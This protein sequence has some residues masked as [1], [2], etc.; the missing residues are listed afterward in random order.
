[1]LRFLLLSAALL[2]SVMNSFAS[3]DHRIIFFGDS[4]TDSGY[5]NNNPILKKEGKTPLWTSP[6]GHTWAYYF[7]QNYAHYKHGYR[8][9]LTPNNVDAATFFHPVPAHI[10]PILDGNN[11]AAGGSTTSGAGMINSKVYKSPS[12]LNQTDY[13][14]KTYA[15]Q[16]AI[17]VSEPTYLIWSGTNDVL[18]HLV[19]QIAIAEWLQKLHLYKLTSALHFFDLKTLSTRFNKIEHRISNN[20]LTAVTHL[21]KAGA[22]KIVVILLPDIG[23]SP[24]MNTLVENLQK[25]GNSITG[26]Q[27]AAAM[28]VTTQNTNAL[29]R[30]TLANT[31]VLL[32][33]VDRLLKLVTTM[34][35]PG[36]FRES[37][38]DF[39]KK[40][41]FFIANNTKSACK[42]TEQAL[43]CIPRVANAEHYLFEDVLH[44]TDQTHQIIGDY[45]FYQS[46]QYLH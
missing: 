5:Q 7:L 24:L 38:P 22:K 40:R 35:T 21:Q 46:R 23:D 30:N 45:I 8:I 18:K 41:T 26:S 29:I 42:P 3:Q 12:L 34:K 27:L 32:I 28:H 16:H 4:L 31:H 39:G 6:N 1:M 37:M 13:F 43:T 25:K 36:T 33:D 19:I 9:S 17:S 10:K 11:F 20:L 2:L 14:L 44:P 15:P